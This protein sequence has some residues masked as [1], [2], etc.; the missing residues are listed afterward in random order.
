[1]ATANHASQAADDAEP[2]LQRYLRVLFERRW[3]LLFCLCAGIALFVTWASRAPRI[4]QATATVIV[5]P[6]AP[7]V[8]AGDVRDVVQVGPG[9]YYAMQDYLQTQRRVLTSDSLARRVVRRLKLT[10]DPQFWPEGAPRD[11]DEAVHRFAGAVTADPLVDTQIVTVSFRHRLPAQA[12]RATD[13]LADAFIDANLE[14]RDSSTTSASHFLSD[15]TDGLRQRLQSAELALFQFKKDSGLLSVSIEDHLNNVS[16]QI[17]KLSDAL[18]DARLRKMARGSEADELGRMVDETAAVVAPSSVTGGDALL[19]LKKDLVEEERK[20][21]ELQARY[22]DVH[23]LVRQ[24]LAKVHAVQQAIHR[25]G[26]SQLRAAQARTSE[27]AEEERKISAQLDETKREAL[28][29]TRLEIDYNRLKREADALGKQY[30]MVQSRTKETELAGQVKANNL[31]V[32][33]YARMPGT[34][35]AP[36]LMRGGVLAVSASLLVGLLMALLLDLLDRSIKTTEDLEV[37][38]RVPLLGMMP[39]V[40]KSSA[41]VELHVAESPNS[42]AAESCRLIRTNLAFAGSARPLKRLLITSPVAREGKTMISVSIATVLAQ[43]GGRV[44]LIDGDLRRPRVRQALGLERADLG[45]TNVLLGQASLED[46]IRPTSIPNLF[47]LLSG[48]LPPNPAELVDTPAY[49]QLI[50]ECAAR[51]DRVIVDSPPSVP[52]A[53]PVI[54]ASHCDGVI[55]VVR[56]GRTSRDQ[57]AKARR[58]LVDVGAHIIGAVLNDCDVGGRGYRGY[59]YSAGEYTSEL[60]RDAGVPPPRGRASA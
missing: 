34:P 24:Q 13:G 32:L 33:D 39:R 56:A 7:Q 2:E 10:S 38:L 26:A 27:A 36:N 12:K 43:A 28:R 52:V 42:A 9:Q 19:G 53:D 49:R 3:V 31:H 6:T 22:E 58:N 55:L 8:F 25:E 59:R 18:T 50:D 46:A 45:L 44:L 30:A 17:D 57:A 16:R 4:Y 1:M 23:P 48:P 41:R 51:F 20:L 37:R 40:A 21:G 54:M 35:V 47:V 15:E 14:L 11:E 29:M 60:R 5:D